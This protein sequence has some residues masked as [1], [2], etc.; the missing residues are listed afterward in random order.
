MSPPI[1]PICIH[2]G[3][4]MKGFKGNYLFRECAG[5]QYV[6]HYACGLNHL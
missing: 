6:G 5:Y 2:T 1:V 3:L 4:F